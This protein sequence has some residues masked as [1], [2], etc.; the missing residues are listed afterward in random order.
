MA[1]ECLTLFVRDEFNHMYVE[2]LVLLRNI[3]TLNRLLAINQTKFLSGIE[4]LY[5]HENP[6]FVPT[7]PV[8][9]FTTECMSLKELCLS[10]SQICLN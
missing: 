4:V 3:L 1:L 8:N 6:I 7:I 5:K 9:I 10:I 2:Y